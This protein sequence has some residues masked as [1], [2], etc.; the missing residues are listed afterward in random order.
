MH[1]EYFKNQLT[2]NI[3]QNINYICYFSLPAAKETPAASKRKSSNGGGGVES[4]END[5]PQR[6]KAGSYTPDPGA[7]NPTTAD[8]G[9]GNPMSMNTNINNDPLYH[10]GDMFG[11]YNSGALLESFTYYLLT[12]KVTDAKNI[13]LGNFGTETG[14]PGRT[15]FGPSQTENYCDQPGNAPR[16]PSPKQLSFYSQTETCE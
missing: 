10:I 4:K 13:F 6:K 12:A 1:F 15:P 2:Q 7:G 16:K 11:L 14:G 9:A 5:E 8:F 3:N